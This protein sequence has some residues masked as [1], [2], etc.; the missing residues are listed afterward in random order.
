MG[1]TRRIALIDMT[2]HIDDAQLATVAAAINLQVTRDLMRY[3]PVT[4]T[5][6]AL[7]SSV[8]IPPGVW[9]L[10]VVTRIDDTTAGFHRTQQ[11][12]P[13]AEVED[14][15]G[16][17][18]AASHEILE[19]LIDPSG[20]D[21]VTATAV[22]LEGS[23]QSDAD[24]CFQYLLEICDPCEHPDCAYL[25]DGVVVSDFCTPEFYG[26]DHVPGA[27]YT[28]SG[29]IDAPRRVLK[30]GYMSW[31]NAEKNILERLDYTDQTVD[32]VIKNVGRHPP[33]SSLREFVDKEM[34][35]SV[36]LPAML[37]D[38]PILARQRR[39]AAQMQR[40]ALHHALR[41]R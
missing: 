16:W 29:S 12:Q 3:W 30:G 22:K 8:S 25:V 36:S 5:V 14:S 35:N 7:P 28:F 13:Y 31:W 1:L 39:H 18:L 2:G 23:M 19:M 32:P 11:Y 21:L 33:N 24:G 38:H 20:N 41:F 6:S 37:A 40:A 17:T 34:R 15:P 4:A 9:P 10:F 27:R 26:S